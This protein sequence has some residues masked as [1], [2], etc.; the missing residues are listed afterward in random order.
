MIEPWLVGINQSR[1]L[2]AGRHKP[3]GESDRYTGS[4]ND[5]ARGRRHQPIESNDVAV[6]SRQQTFEAPSGRYASAL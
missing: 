5:R 1:N 2:V 4:G 3:L 6:T